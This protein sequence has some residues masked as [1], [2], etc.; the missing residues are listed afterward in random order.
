MLGAALVVAALFGAT[1]VQRRERLQAAVNVARA[2]RGAGFTLADFY[3]VTDPTTRLVYGAAWAAGGAW[4][5]SAAAIPAILT[6]RP[7]AAVVAGAGGAAAGAQFGWNMTQDASDII[8]GLR[9]RLI[10]A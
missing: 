8:I 10:G 1:V 6:G 9:K 2:T 7:A 5:G 4:L 3:A